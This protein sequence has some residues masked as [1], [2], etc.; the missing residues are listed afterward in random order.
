M[1]E[2]GND[3]RENALLEG[4]MNEESVVHCTLLGYDALVESLAW[5]LA[6]GAREAMRR[7]CM[8][9]KC[10]Q[11]DEIEKSLASCEAVTQAPGEEPPQPQGLNLRCPLCGNKQYASR[12]APHLEKCMGRGRQG[13][14]PNKQQQH[15]EVDLEPA[16]SNGSTKPNATGRRST[17]TGANNSTVRR[18]QELRK[19][20]ATN[21][22]LDTLRLALSST[23]TLSVMVLM[24]GDDPQGSFMGERGE[25]G[26]SG[27]C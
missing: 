20:L 26:D 1:G 11:D 13:A 27:S 7:N 21:V 16:P 25:Q 22:S 19:R 8:A 17:S 5:E 18:M 4:L 10:E 15:I 2:D 9:V 14:R 12:F 23:I 6:L 3:D 24:E